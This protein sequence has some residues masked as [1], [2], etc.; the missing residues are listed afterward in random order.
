MKGKYVTPRRGSYVIL[1]LKKFEKM[2]LNQKKLFWFLS[3]LSKWCKQIHGANENEGR[4]ACTKHWWEK[5][6]LGIIYFFWKYWKFYL[7]DRQPYFGGI[8]VAMQNRWRVSGLLFFQLKVFFTVVKMYFK[9]EE[10]EYGI[11]IIN[12]CWLLTIF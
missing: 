12:I 8:T 1:E 4:T 7:C 9:S 3:S 5:R 10:S 2:R 6:I 11:K